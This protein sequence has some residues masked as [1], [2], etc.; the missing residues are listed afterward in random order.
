MEKNNNNKSIDEKENLNLSDNRINNTLINAPTDNEKN[1][2]D[3]IKMDFIY[4]DILPVLIADFLQDYPGIVLVDKSNELRN[5]MK[6]L[7]DNEILHKLGDL[8]KNDLQEEKINKTKELLFEKMNVE[9]NLDLYEDLLIKNKA[10][11]RN[12]IFIEG[13]LQKL[14]MQKMYL[15]KKIKEYQEEDVEDVKE[16]YNR[17]SKDRMEENNRKASHENSRDDKDRDRLRDRERSPIR[18][19]PCK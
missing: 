3:Q 15:E 18:M 5:E 2:A 1:I 9:R 13:M 17:I 12:T 11:G 10:V 19:E 6:A 14:K 7:F 4:I 8:A 16:N